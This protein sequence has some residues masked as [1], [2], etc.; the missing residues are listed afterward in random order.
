[1]KGRPGTGKNEI[2][3]NPQRNQGARKKNMEIHEEW[4][5]DSIGKNEQPFSPGLLG[6]DKS[7]MSY[8]IKS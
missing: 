5:Q 6:D 8:G 4:V 1:M 2:N 3:I 7:H